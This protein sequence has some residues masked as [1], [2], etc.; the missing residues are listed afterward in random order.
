VAILLGASLASTGA[1][2]LERLSQPFRDVFLVL[3]FVFFGITV[4]F[5]GTS[6]LAPIVA[7]T[8]IAIGSKILTG[9]IVGRLLHG[10]YAAGMEIG[11]T[12]IARGE[13]SIAFA[14]IYGSGA[15]SA[16][17]AA[18]VILTSLAGSFAARFSDRLK[19]FL[20]P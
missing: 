10:S 12:I 2:L 6:S 1:P 16:L 17:L 8:L 15:I 3:F 11:A 7:M 9:L 20:P 4:D 13:F 19:G 14:A 5:S 18:V